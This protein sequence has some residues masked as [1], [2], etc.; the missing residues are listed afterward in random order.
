MVIFF[1]SSICMLYQSFVLEIYNFLSLPA[2][3][4]FFISH[5]L[6]FPERTKLVRVFQFLSIFT[7]WCNILTFVNL[8]IVFSKYDDH[9]CCGI[10]FF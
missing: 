1:M 9:P 3:S 10:D 6:L 7:E 8:F 2:L 5:D 4:P